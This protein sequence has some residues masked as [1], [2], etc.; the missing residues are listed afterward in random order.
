MIVVDKLAAPIAAL[1]CPLVGTAYDNADGSNRLS[2]VMMLAPGQAVELRLEPKNKYDEHAVAVFAPSGVQ[3]GYLPSERAVWIGQLLRRG[4]EAQAILLGVGERG[5]WLRIAF[6]GDE[7]DLLPLPIASAAG[8]GFDP[9]W[10]PDEVW[11]DDDGE[12]QW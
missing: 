8:E 6:D 12:D 5:P 10:Q 1:S 4:H 11:P 9:E 2:E 7:P 3:I